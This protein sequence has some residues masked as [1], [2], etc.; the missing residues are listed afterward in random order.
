M[1]RSMTGYGRSEYAA[2][3]GD[4]IVEVKSSN[5]RFCDISL[6]MPQRCFA[7]EHEIKKLILARLKRGRIDLSIQFENKEQEE[8]NVG[9]NLPLAQRYY[10]LFKELKEMLKL[11]GEITLNQLVTQKDIIVSQSANQDTIYDWEILKGPIS[12]ALDTLVKMRETEGA[13]LHEDF[14]ARLKNIELLLDRIH[15]IA[16]TAFKDHQESLHEKIQSL[17]KN[18]EID[19]TRLAQEV[20]YLVEKSDITEEVVRTQSHLLQFRECF[21]SDDVIGRKLDFLI[22]E[23]H[24]EI[25]TISSKS[26]H[27][28]ISHKAVEIKNE[29]ER[30]REQVQNIE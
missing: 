6:R 14:L 19:E 29:L 16:E 7:L 26:Y 2:E 13:L 17:C 24:R 15:T 10:I 8:L 28:E 21:D 1:L 5:H 12:T 30:M 9:L 22:Q 20:A 18:I 11:P 25:N 3:Q 23:I 4:I 27:A